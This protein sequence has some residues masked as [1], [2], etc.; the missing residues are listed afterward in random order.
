MI[1]KVFQLF[2]KYAVE[3]CLEENESYATR[4]RKITVAV[5]SVSAINGF[6]LGIP[7]AVILLGIEKTVINYFV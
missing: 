1:H 3:P 5:A 6:F 4:S 2:M 7:M